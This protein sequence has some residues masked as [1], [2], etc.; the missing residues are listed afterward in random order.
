MY[1]GD[2]K[3]TQDILQ[4]FYSVITRSHPSLKFNVL[5]KQLDQYGATIRKSKLDYVLS[6]K[7]YSK[8]LRMCCLSSF[9][10]NCGITINEYYL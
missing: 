10:E 5:N 8:S 1:F 4:Y 7:E 3:K 2:N 9:F 6:A